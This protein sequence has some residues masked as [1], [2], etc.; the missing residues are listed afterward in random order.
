MLPTSPRRLLAL[1]GLLLATVLLAGL[2]A[3]T[4]SAG[5]PHTP[6][7]AAAENRSTV[8]I[9]TGGITWSDIDEETTPNLW[10]LVMS[11]S[12]AALG[13]RSINT[14]TCPVDAW[15]GFSA[16]ERAGAPAPDGNPRRA[17]WAPCPGPAPV[18]DD[19]VSNWDRYV[20]AATEL[21]FNA[22]LGTFGDTVTAQG[23]CVSTVGP[24]AALGAAR[25]DGS[26]PHHAT[27]DPAVLP[28]ALSL[29]PIS[30][31]DIGS[32]SQSLV[33][34]DRTHRLA[35]IDAQI[36]EVLDAAPEGANVIV[37]SMSDDG[38]QSQL[39]MA[40]ATGPD[41]GPGVLRSSSTRQSGLIVNNDL[42]TSVLALSGLDIPR[43]VNGAVIVSEPAAD[44]SAE[45]SLE[46]WQAYVDYD[47]KSAK[48]RTLVPTFFQSFIWGQLV[49]YL[50]VLL[51]WKGR[52]GREATRSRWLGLARVVGVGAAAV[53]AATFLANLIPWWRTS[54]PLL[55]IVGAVALWTAVIIALALVPPWGSTALGPV[56]VVSLVTVLVI[57]IDV[58]T[59]SRLQQSSLMGL[60]PAIGGRYFG[61]GNVSFALFVTSAIFFATVVANHFMAQ[62][63]RKAAAVAVAV[64][65][66]VVLIVNGAPMWGADAGGPLSLPVA[67]AFFVLTLLGI[68]LTWKRWAALFAATG[69]IFLSVAY[70][71]SLRPADKQSH[72][73]R[74]FDSIADGHAFDIITRKAAANWSVL[75]SNYSM[76]VLVPFAL[77]FVIYVLARETS[78]GSRALQ[79][80]FDRYPALRPGLL[81]TLVALTV[82]FFVNDS[83][84]A[85]PAVGATIAVPLL[86]AINVHVL[87]R[88]MDPTD[89]PEKVPV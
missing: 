56:G 52:L 53:P 87:R 35:K 89:V 22:R 24:G 66:A 62:G 45:T 83:G 71:D 67:T 19:T 28:E 32:L 15:L 75:T 65:L 10:R 18:S 48:I 3:S 8:L 33:D 51:V 30:L 36:G 34:G 77:A 47:A 41:F 73:G 50:L 6:S 57:G 29:C 69:A 4:A 82:G 78:W 21:R 1:L 80:S 27:Y 13:V 39:R 49:I 12:G 46:R 42:T 5:Q 70:L 40:L 16:G 11:G 25:S 76:T 63:R 86:I 68:R 64:I 59:G 88:E 79:R 17:S 81:T 54:W 55:G 84:V 26:V 14:T 58:M 72:L 23:V 2:G 74:F 38:R 9:G 7:A 37:A 60:Q 43:G 31:V 44:D 20:G 61:L 85:I